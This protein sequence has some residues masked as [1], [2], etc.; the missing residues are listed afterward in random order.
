MSCCTSPYFE[1]SLQDISL[2]PVFMLLTH[3]PFTFWMYQL[4]DRLSWQVLQFSSVSP[5]LFLDIFI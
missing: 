2:K 3:L 1:S 4:S 5:S